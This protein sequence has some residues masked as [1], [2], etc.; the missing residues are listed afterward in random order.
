MSE[1]D[2]L[3]VCRLL[4]AECRTAGS[5]KAWAERHGVSPAF[6][7]DVLNARREPSGA[8]LSALGLVRVVKYAIRRTARAE[9]R[10]GC[11]PAALSIGDEGRPTP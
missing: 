1:V 11:N 6:V 3:D 10:A 8:I 4:R 7:C 5:Q 9:E 2:L